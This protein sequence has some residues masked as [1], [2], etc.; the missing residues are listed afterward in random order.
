PEDPRRVPLRLESALG[1]GARLEDFILPY[2]SPRVGQRLVALGLPKDSLI[3]L[4]GR[5]DQFLV[6]DGG[7]VLEAGDVLW[8][9]ANESGLPRVRDI[10]TESASPAAGGPPP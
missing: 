3:A 9:L 6:P 2:N 5:G 10:L 7:T 1:G 4:I 8:V